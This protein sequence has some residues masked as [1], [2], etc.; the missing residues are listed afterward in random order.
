MVV[1]GGAEAYLIKEKL[2]T[3][4]VP[5][6]LHLTFILHLVILSPARCIPDFW[7]TRR[8]T[9][10]SFKLLKDAGVQVGFGTYDVDNVRNLVREFSSRC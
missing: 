6:T 1:V 7:D 9:E 5:G 2:A 8:C 4:Q 10:D 3:E